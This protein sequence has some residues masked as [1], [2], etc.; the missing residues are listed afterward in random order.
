MSIG[1]KGA[2]YGVIT[3]MLCVAV[4]LN[5]S[6][7]KDPTDLSVAN[8]INGVEETGKIYGEAKV[9]DSVEDNQDA[10]VIS[11]DNYFASARLSREKARDE[12][13][14]ILKQ[15]IDNQNA[16]EESKND[17]NKQINSLEDRKSDE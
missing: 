12:A 11:A 8:D 1:K 17:A 3:L 14:S 10:Q 9:V 4:Y 15:T 6:Y 2:V 16:T 5:W 13:I 7:Q